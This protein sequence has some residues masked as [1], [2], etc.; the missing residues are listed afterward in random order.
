MKHDESLPTL[1]SI[2]TKQKFLL[3]LATDEVL[4]HGKYDLEE[5]YDL[6]KAHFKRMDK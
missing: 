2:D 4:E 6:L 1:S 3:W 5:F